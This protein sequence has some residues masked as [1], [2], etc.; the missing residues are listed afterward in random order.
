MGISNS[1]QDHN[2]ALLLCK[3][4]VCF[5]KRAIDSRYALSAAQLSYLQ[6]LRNVGQALRQFVEAET[7]TELPQSP[8]H[9]SYASLSP[10]PMPDPSPLLNGTPSPYKK[11]DGVSY[12]RAS[13]VVPMQLSIDLNETHFMEGENSSWDFFDPTD[14]DP[15]SDRSNTKKRDSISPIDEEI[16]LEFSTPIGNAEAVGN[17]RHGNENMKD[18][19]GKGDDACQFITHRAKDMVSSMREIEHQFIKAAES[20]HEVSRMLET[21]KIRL[22]VSSQTIGLAFYISIC[23]RFLFLLGIFN[24]T[25]IAYLY[26]LYT[27]NC[28]LQSF[29]YKNRIYNFLLITIHKEL[30]TVP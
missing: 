21:K 24:S 20:G 8:S 25:S 9:S 29:L 19:I 28:N 22:T 15:R 11:N 14:T 16:E 27:L 7:S 13:G 23:F 30:K 4:R 6:S 18:E 12:M 10:S 1:K 5:V 26:P 17:D 2:T 3:D